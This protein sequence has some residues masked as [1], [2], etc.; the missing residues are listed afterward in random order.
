MASDSI[1]VLAWK[2]YKNN[3]LL[4]FYIN[5]L[6]QDRA[7]LAAVTDASLHGPQFFHPYAWVEC[8]QRRL[9]KMAST[10]ATGS[11]GEVA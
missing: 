9:I 5:A 1:M 2:N 4:S 6:A 8:L 7:V 3:P 10:P 11:G